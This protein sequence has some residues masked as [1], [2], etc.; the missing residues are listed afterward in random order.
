[1][2]SFSGIY[3]EEKKKQSANFTF[4]QGLINQDY[5]NHLYSIFKDYS[6]SPPKL[7]TSKPH[8]KTGKCYISVLFYSYSLP[9]FNELYG[10]FSVLGKKV[11]PNNIF[12]LLT[13]FSLAYWIADDVSWNK[14][15]KYETFCTDSF[16]LA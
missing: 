4:K 16:T 14:V 12:Y 6:G 3:T 5:L 15:G 8:P 1:L 2:D 7:E 9:C 13:P 11:I 10:S